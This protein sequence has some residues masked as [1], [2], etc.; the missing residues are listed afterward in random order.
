MVVR[1]LQLAN[2]RRRGAALVEF[3]LL[4]PLFLALVVGT[5]EGGQALDASNTLTSAVREAGRLAA[6]D[7][8][9]SIPNGKTPNQKI[10]DDIRH[11][12]TASGLDGDDVEITITA[13]EGSDAGGN[14]D[15]SDPD[16]NL[17]LFRIS[18]EV[19]Y[20]NVSSFPAT[21]MKGQTITASL[22]FRAGR[23]TLSN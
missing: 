20:K 3:A 15:L 16:N 17:K 4:A 12:I 23:V 2:H 8:E 7:W 6:M 21:F 1:K 18:A 14:F 11:F 22:V 5:I 13:A 10:I 9:D 19:D